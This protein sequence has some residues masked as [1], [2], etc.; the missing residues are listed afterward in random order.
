MNRVLSSPR[1]TRPAT[2]KRTRRH[3]DGSATHCRQRQKKQRTLSPRHVTILC[4]DGI[5]QSLLQFL[6]VEAIEAMVTT[7]EA[8]LGSSDNTH[9]VLWDEAFWSRI[10]QL[11]FGAPAPLS[12]STE[13][14]RSQLSTARARVLTAR[15]CEFGACQALL[16]FFAW[17]HE[18]EWFDHHTVIIMGD[19]HRMD[20][21]AAAIHHEA[22]SD[23]MLH[24][25]RIRSGVNG[26]WEW[27]QGVELESVLNVHALDRSCP[28]AYIVSARNTQAR[29]L[30]HFI[31]PSAAMT[32]PWEAL[33]RS[34]GA[35]VD[36]I[37]REDLRNVAMV[38]QSRCSGASLTTAA[39]TGLRE[40]QRHLM[41]RAWSGTIGI[42][43]YDKE[44]FQAFK[45]QKEKILKRFGD[46]R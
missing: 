28:H 3:R 9:G 27:G 6:E 26:D 33:C 4:T 34:F 11:H 15:R 46:Y 23:I 45:V 29:S 44:S 10:V 22:V 21:D 43:C 30:I 40:I 35:A 25:K 31:D 1:V 24:K 7:I 41:T 38:P 37:E 32:A 12:F 39:S 13:R 5:T 8:S 18:R 17:T 20:P 2:L 14:L 42:V 36:A 19:A 16:Q